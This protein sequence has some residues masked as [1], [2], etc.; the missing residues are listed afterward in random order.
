MSLDLT[1]PEG[2]LGSTRLSLEAGD[3]LVQLHRVTD[4]FLSSLLPVVPDRRTALIITG[5]QRQHPEL[6]M[7]CGRGMVQTPS[8][9][10]S[11][12]GTGLM[13]QVLALMLATRSHIPEHYYK[14]RHGQRAGRN[15]HSKPVARP[16]LFIKLCR[17][18]YYIGMAAR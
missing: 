16:R 3:L 7:Y 4:D 14:S 5:K 1:G 11:A 18:C 17:L 2:P 13:R 10:H 15:R 6:T 9:C 8:N 12:T